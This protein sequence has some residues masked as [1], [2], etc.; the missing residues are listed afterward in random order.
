MALRFPSDSSGRSR[1]VSARTC[2]WSLLMSGIGTSST[3]PTRPRRASTCFWR[4]RAS[5]PPN[6]CP[7]ASYLL[8]ASCPSGDSVSSTS[9][10]T[11]LLRGS[12]PVVSDVTSRT[13]RLGRYVSDVTSRT[14]RIRFVSDVT[15]RTLRIRFV[16]ADVSPVH[17]NAFTLAPAAISADV[18]GMQRRKGCAPDEPASIARSPQRSQ[19]SGTL[20]GT[21]GHSVACSSQRCEEP[22]KEPV[23]EPVKERRSGGKRALPLDQSRAAS[24]RPRRT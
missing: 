23:K 5:G 17:Y 14:L 12:I 15:S 24:K 19:Q 3:C 11:G 13:L 8:P 6:L 21:Q 7:H 2:T 10:D 20:R 16:S 4:V 9:S 18:D 22:A 1:T